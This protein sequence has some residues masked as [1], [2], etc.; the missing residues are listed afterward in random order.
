MTDLI[1]PA[2]WGGAQWVLLCILIY[3]LTNEDDTWPIKLAGATLML[4]ILAWGGFW[5]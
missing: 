5:A 1:N 3:N 2:N 4:A